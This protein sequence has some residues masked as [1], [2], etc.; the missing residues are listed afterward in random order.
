VETAARSG[1]PRRPHEA[2]SRLR[3]R[4][5]PHVVA[6]HVRGGR[7]AR[8]CRARSARG[9]A[10]APRVRDLRVG[11]HAGRSFVREVHA[12]LRCVRRRSARLDHGRGRRQEARR[13]VE[14]RDA[15]DV[16]HGHAEQ[17]RSEAR[18]LRPR[19]SARLADLRARS[20]QL[21]ELGDALRRDRAGVF[22]PGA[23]R[24]HRDARVRRFRPGRGAARRRRDDEPERLR[25]GTRRKILRRLGEGLV[26]EPRAEAALDGRVQEARD[27][28]A[29]R[30]V[31]EGDVGQARRQRR[32]ARPPRRGR[33]LPR[34]RRP[35]HGPQRSTRTRPSGSSSTKRFAPSCG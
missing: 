30:A 9:R 22:A 29:P 6:D 14:P 23:R 16:P 2:P 4:S 33:D 18:R 27:R 8:R 31:R 12:P 25:R 34:A 17:E 1:Q 20:L 24:D 3:K 26:L 13:L 35:G 32:D 21:R 11:R 15:H 10:R 19:S 5:A 7:G 28:R